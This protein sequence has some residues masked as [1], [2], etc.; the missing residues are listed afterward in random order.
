VGPKT[1]NDL[2]IIQFNVNIFIDS[3]GGEKAELG[4]MPRSSLFYLL[5]YLLDIWECG[6]NVQELNYDYSCE[7]LVLNNEEETPIK[8]LSARKASRPVLLRNAVSW[9][10]IDEMTTLFGNMTVQVWL[11]I[12]LL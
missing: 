1:K 11:F 12:P 8:F 5:I 4:S 7:L 2:P 3:V 6:C 10:T 9:P